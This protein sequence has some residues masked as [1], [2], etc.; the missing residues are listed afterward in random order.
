MAKTKPE[1]EAAASS[2]APAAA[3][4]ASS[5]LRSSGGSDV[6][7]GLDLS[8]DRTGNVYLERGAR[9]TSQP[10]QGIWQ[11]VERDEL[12]DPRWDT[13]EKH[14]STPRRESWCC[15]ATSFTTT[16]LTKGATGP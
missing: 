7:K 6:V 8:R 12:R 15:S 14:T 3:A 9:D 1:P 4:A 2:A 5:G 10:V 16:L 11:I 13:R